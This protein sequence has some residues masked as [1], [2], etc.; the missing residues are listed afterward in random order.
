[1]TTQI[2][3][4]LNM[5]EVASL[6]Q[7]SPPPGQLYSTGQTGSF[8]LVALKPSSVLSLSAWSK[9]GHSHTV[10]RS[11]KA[12]GS[13]SPGQVAYLQIGNDLQITHI[14]THIPLAFYLTVRK[15]GKCSPIWRGHGPS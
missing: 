12:V 6:I 10:T 11:L 7:S 15:T 1:M 8:H 5:I 14:S 4:A 13:V 9:L 2:E 3:W